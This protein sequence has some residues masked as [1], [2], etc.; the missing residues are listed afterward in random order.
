M[1]SPIENDSNTIEL[2]LLTSGYWV[3]DLICAI[4]L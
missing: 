1:L 2:T 3:L 4:V